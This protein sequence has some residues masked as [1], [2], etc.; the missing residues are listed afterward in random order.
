MFFNKTLY[1]F[2]SIRDV[3]EYEVFAGASFSTDRGPCSIDVAGLGE[4]DF[5]LMRIN[6]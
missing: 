6:F 5:F 2:L 1:A 4:I 3:R